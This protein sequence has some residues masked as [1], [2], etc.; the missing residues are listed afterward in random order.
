MQTAVEGSFYGAYPTGG[1]LLSFTARVSTQVHEQPFT[2]GGNY[3][4][5][6]LLS[7]R[8]RDI[9]DSSS[10][11]LSSLRGSRILRGL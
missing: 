9:C 6:L 2:A 8:M 7:L 3:A 4:T 5:M 1:R 10:L 11:S